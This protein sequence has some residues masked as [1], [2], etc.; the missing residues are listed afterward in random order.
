MV[1]HGKETMGSLYRIAWL[2]MVNPGMAS[3]HGATWR[4]CAHS[5]R[6][7]KNENE[8]NYFILLISFSL[9]IQKSELLCNSRLFSPPSPWLTPAGEDG[10]GRPTVAAPPSS[11]ATL[12]PKPKCLNINPTYFRP[13]NPNPDSF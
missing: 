11:P 13:E 7:F 8:K 2:T 1:I 3:L 12:T 10:G 9:F 4:T 6:P 5:K